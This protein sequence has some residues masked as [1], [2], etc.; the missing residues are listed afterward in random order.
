MGAEMGMSAT[1]FCATSSASETIMFSVSR[2]TCGTAWRREFKHAL[3]QFMQ[4]RP[5]LE[6]L[7]AQG[8]L[9]LDAALFIAWHGDV[10]SRGMRGGRG[11]FAGPANRRTSRNGLGNVMVSDQDFIAGCGWWRC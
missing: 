7:F 9:A 8:L 6:Q 4:F 11:P 5:L 10:G 3:H 1:S 2:T